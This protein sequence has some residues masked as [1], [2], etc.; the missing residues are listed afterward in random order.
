MTGKKP[1]NQIVR[2]G[3]QLHTTAGLRRQR[4]MRAAAPDLLAALVDLVEWQEMIADD[5][6]IDRARAAIAKARGQQ[7]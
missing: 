1:A 7:P 3:G 2:V 5:P 6:K 4:I